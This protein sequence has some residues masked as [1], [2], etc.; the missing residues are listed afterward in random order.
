MNKTL[1][2]LTKV[3]IFMILATSCAQQND[4]YT[5]NSRSSLRKEQRVREKNT[6]YWDRQDRK[7]N[8]AEL[9]RQKKDEKEYRKFMKKAKKRHHDWQSDEVKKRIKRNEKAAQKEMRKNAVLICD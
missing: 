7:A 4:M 5:I 8:K 3:I 6:R 2:Q 1:I 9:K